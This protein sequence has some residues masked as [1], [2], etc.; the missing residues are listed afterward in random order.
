[1]SR[2]RFIPP[3]ISW[4]T[5]DARVELRGRLR[6]PGDPTLRAHTG[7]VGRTMLDIR[8][9]SSIRI[10]GVSFDTMGEAST[11]V[12]IRDPFQFSV[13]DAPHEL[14]QCSFRGGIRTVEPGALL[15]IQ[16]SHPYTATPNPFIAHSAPSIVIE[17]CL[18]EIDSVDGVAV[19]LLGTGASAEFRGCTFVGHAAAM[20]HASSFEVVTTSCRFQ[21]ELFPTVLAS[22]SLSASTRAS[23]LALH[24]CPSPGRSRC[25]P[26][27][28]RASD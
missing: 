10:Q 22:S 7:F 3:M 4:H 17:A 26:R 25:V 16:R 21:N 24:S 2:P 5:D 8:A 12:A 23:I 15:R 28:R 6:S 14:T 9:V 27:L 1:M 18:F 20:I 13:T 11:C 19:R